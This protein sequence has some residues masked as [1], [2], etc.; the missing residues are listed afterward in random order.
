M[1]PARQPGTG[2]LHR[3]V[4]PL[5][6][7]HLA[8]MRRCEDFPPVI[9][10]QAQFLSDQGYLRPRRAAPEVI[11]RAREEFYGCIADKDR[12]RT[13]A[14]GAAIY[15]LKPLVN[16]S[17]IQRLITDELDAVLRAYYEGPY[18]IDAVRAWRN[19]HIPAQDS[20]V[21]VGISNAFHNDGCDRKNLT[22]FILL[23][24]GVTRDTGA[25][26]FHPK[27]RLARIVRRLGFFSRRWKTAAVKRELLD[28]LTYF[29][30]D[31]G[32]IMVR[33]V[34]ECLHAFSIPSKGTFRDMLAFVIHP[35]QENVSREELFTR[36]PADNQIGA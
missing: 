29:E 9:A 36:I 5:A 4:V 31:A 17:S 1:R 26:R 21:D 2:G 23:S 30:G 28:N 18:L 3:N 27:H 15:A 32:D 16:M 20:T 24:D 12:S 11:Q 33:N 13:Y 14:G 7:A 6:R 22:L 19:H 34:Q 35:G 8:K 25:T 10:E